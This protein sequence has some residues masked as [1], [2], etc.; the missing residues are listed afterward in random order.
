MGDIFSCCYA[1]PNNTPTHQLLGTEAPPPYTDTFP[2]PALL[3]QLTLS[4][5]AQFRLAQRLA[6]I[7]ALPAGIY[8]GAS[9][10]FKRME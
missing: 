10:E 6:L 9:T 2:A 3:R 1:T 7:Q 4:E 5:E 8:D